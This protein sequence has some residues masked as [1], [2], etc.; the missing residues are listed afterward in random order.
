MLSIFSQF[1]FGNS[2]LFGKQHSDSRSS[3]WKDKSL[4]FDLSQSDLELNHGEQLIA[5]F[6]PIEDIKGNQD[7]LGLL[8]VTN[9]RY[10]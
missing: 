8:S 5:C 2:S 10:L 3:T 7:E 1:I 9:L 4:C 6:F